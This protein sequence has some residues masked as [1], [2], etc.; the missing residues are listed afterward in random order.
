M[1]RAGYLLRVVL[2]LAA[3]A[4]AVA[5]VR[6]RGVS[7]EAQ[8]VSIARTAFARLLY[9]PIGEPTVTLEGEQGLAWALERAHPGP[10]GVSLARREG[11]AAEN[12]MAIKT[13]QKT[14]WGMNSPKQAETIAGAW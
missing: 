8:A 12:K 6:G 13:R 7:G 5:L 14:P 4:A 10:G 3:A 2:A 11:G 1:S 9:Q